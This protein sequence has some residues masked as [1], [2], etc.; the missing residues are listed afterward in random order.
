MWDAKSD[1]SRVLE[2]DGPGCPDLVPSVFFFVFFFH[3]FPSLGLLEKEGN[4]EEVK[5]NKKTNMR[6]IFVTQK[7]THALKHLNGPRTSELL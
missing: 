3:S 2:S 4:R 6:M 1:N 7:V 5:T